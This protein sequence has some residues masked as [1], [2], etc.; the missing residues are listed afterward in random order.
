MITFNGDNFTDGYQVIIT[1]FKRGFCTREKE[2]I[3]VAI[4]DGEQMKPHNIRGCDI[5]VSFTFLNV[6][7]ASAGTVISMMKA[8][9]D[10]TSVAIL[11]IPT[12][13]FEEDNCV[14]NDVQLTGNE[15][16]HVNINGDFESEEVKSLTFEM[17]F[18]QL[19]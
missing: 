4:G 2:F 8:F 9:R 6:P 15:W 17:T 3:P 5:S 13:N 18:R 10:N 12:E 19:I 16:G 1:D 7:I 11:S 14:I